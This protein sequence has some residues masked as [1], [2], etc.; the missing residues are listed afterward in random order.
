M[1]VQ[2]G[3][4]ER[5]LIFTLPLLTLLFIWIR[6]TKNKKELAQFSKQGAAFFSSPIGLVSPILLLLTLLFGSIAF[7]GPKGDPKLKLREGEDITILIDLSESMLEKGRLDRASQILDRFL[8]E[9]KEGRVALIEGTSGAFP[10][11]PLTENRLFLRATLH[12]LNPLTTEGVGSDFVKQFIELKG[13]EGLLLFV[14]DGEDQISKKQ[15]ILEAAMGLKRE[16]NTLFVGSDESGKELLQEIASATHGAF[17]ENEKELLSWYSGKGGLSSLE[18]TP[19][20]IYPLTI[21]LT[22]LTLFLLREQMAF[23]LFLFALP[24]SASLYEGDDALESNDLERAKA[25]YGDTGKEVLQGKEERLILLFGGEKFVPKTALEKALFAKFVDPLSSIDPLPFL[26]KEQREGFKAGICQ[27][28]PWD[29]VIPLITKAKERESE[30]ALFAAAVLW[31]EA[32]SLLAKGEASPQETSEENSSLKALIEMEKS[33]LDLKK[34]SR[35]S[36]L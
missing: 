18:F 24:L 14:S 9:K 30:G 36:A 4:S 35:G 34:R 32:L 33:D 19:L 13:R 7:M 23:A 2:F 22:F 5:A 25:L 16:V 6:S 27:L 31:R 11:V 10:I 21:A 28:S 15:D 17:F 20:F 29:R 12:A 1:M 3:E 26:L 8:L